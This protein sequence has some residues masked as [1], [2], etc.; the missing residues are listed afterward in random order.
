MVLPYFA[1]RLVKKI[2][3]SLSQPIKS[4]TKPILTCSQSFRAWRRL[5]VFACPSDWFIVLFVTVV[6]GQ[7]NCFCFAI[8]TRRKTALTRP[9]NL[10]TDSKESIKKKLQFHDETEFYFH[11]SEQFKLAGADVI[12]AIQLNSKI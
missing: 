8:T 1:L 11:F 2:T 10:L 7:S 9:S 12:Y 6:I 5:R 4:E 3:A